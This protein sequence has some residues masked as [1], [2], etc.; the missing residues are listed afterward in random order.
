MKNAAIQ[1]GNQKDLPVIARVN[2]YGHYPLIE[3]KENSL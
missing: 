3:E 1:M 2:Q